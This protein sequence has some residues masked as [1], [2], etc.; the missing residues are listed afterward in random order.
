M[1]IYIRSNQAKYPYSPVVSNN[2][3]IIRTINNVSSK[4]QIT[5]TSIK[6]IQLYNN[7]NVPITSLSIS[8]QD[9]LLM[10]LSDTYIRTSSSG[11]FER[12]DKISD[13]LTFDQST[14]VEIKLVSNFQPPEDIN[15]DGLFIV[16]VS[17]SANLES[18][19]SLSINAYGKLDN[20]DQIQNNLRPGS[21]ILLMGEKWA[22][23]SIDYTVIERTKNRSFDVDIKMSLS[24]LISSYKQK[25]SWAERNPVRVIDFNT[26]ANRNGVKSELPQ[27]SIV[28]PE[29]GI[30]GEAIDWFSYASDIAKIN[31]GIIL[32]R[33][34]IKFVKILGVTEPS[35]F[36]KQ[37]KIRS[38]IAIASSD[39]NDDVNRFHQKLEYSGKNFK[40]SKFDDSNPIRSGEFQGSLPIENTTFGYY[41]AEITGDIYLTDRRSIRAEI[42]RSR[43]N[44]KTFLRR[45]RKYNRVQSGSRIIPIWMN[46]SKVVDSISLSFDQS[47]YVQTYSVKETLDGKPIR[48]VIYEYGFVITG[49]DVKD[50]KSLI[51]LWQPYEY[52]VTNYIYDETY[53]Y[54]VGESTT[55]WTLVREESENIREPEGF[56]LEAN[57]P[58]LSKYEFTRIPIKSGKYLELQKSDDFYPTSDDPT[59]GYFINELGRIQEDPTFVPEWLV[60][61]EEEFNVSYKTYVSEIDGL[62]RYSGKEYVKVTENKIY[63]TIKTTAP[64]FLNASHFSDSEK[65][66]I[67]SEEYY[68]QTVTEHGA[69]DEQFRNGLG[70][71]SN[72]IIQGRPSTGDRLPSLYDDYQE[73][74]EDDKP[75]LLKDIYSKIYV[76]SNGYDGVSLHT[77]SV[78][79]ARTLDDV[80]NALKVDW[81][82]NNAKANTAKFTIEYNVKIY[83]GMLCQ[84]AFDG[85]FL[86]GFILSYSHKTS[87]L[88]VNKT[89]GKVTNSRVSET[90]LTL[91]LVNLDDLKNINSIVTTQKQNRSLSLFRPYYVGTRLRGTDRLTATTVNRFN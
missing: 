33:D 77:V 29:T 63:N 67:E 56:D 45:T 39:S 42:E 12:L 4:L 55:G 65:S 80:E 61:L 52:K 59:Q 38:A 81:I 9:K 26:L 27:Y 91:G 31:G 43:I 28:L 74:S 78:N 23:T 73:N 83:E 5:K 14:S 24:S 71:S 79:N 40:P 72:T 8:K 36:I 3:H 51:N 2:G 84:V 70:I 25:I 18:A 16:S 19:R 47:G 64:Q 48:E 58:E 86:Y 20:I 89:T 54:Y 35:L 37:S 57:D 49:Q 1:T 30:Y 85:I 10:N 53:G 41:N 50:A 34:S 69:Q 66:K 22:V 87:K 62:T 17:I 82:L 11:K 76:S 90:E 15:I 44:D 13:I 88:T 6:R 75:T 46:P 68:I 21:E 7:N 60:M 32:Y